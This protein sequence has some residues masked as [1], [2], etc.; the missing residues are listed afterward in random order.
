MEHSASKID[1]FRLGFLERVRPRTAK[2]SEEVELSTH[3]GVEAGELR[4][5]A[6]QVR[7]SHPGV[8]ALLHIPVDRIG[9]I[10]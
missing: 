1:V 7:R 9:R 8:A 4:E 5:P 6:L 2:K 10:I 3:G